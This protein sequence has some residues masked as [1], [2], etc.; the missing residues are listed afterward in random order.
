[1]ITAAVPLTQL[2]AHLWEAANI[3]RGLVDAADC[4]TYVFPL[5]FCKRFFDVHDEE[6]HTAQEESGGDEAYARFPQHSPFQVPDG[7]HWRDVRAVIRL[8]GCSRVRAACGP[9]PMPSRP[10]MISPSVP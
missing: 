7:C 1:M 6:Y 10:S 8:M 3:L 5:L 4:K 9:R 2:A